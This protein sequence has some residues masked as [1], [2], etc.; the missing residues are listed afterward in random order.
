MM[1][2][3]QR[4]SPTRGNSDRSPR[5]LPEH[6]VCCRRVQ[7]RMRGEVPGRTGR[8][9]RAAARVGTPRS[10]AVECPDLHSARRLGGGHG[11]VNI[12][13]RFDRA[14]AALHIE[15]AISRFVRRGAECSEGDATRLCSSRSVGPVPATSTATPWLD[16]QTMA[17][18]TIVR[19]RG[20]SRFG[21]PGGI[22]TPDLLI[23]SQSL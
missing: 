2:K 6:A 7:A 4:L 1:A 3:P 15:D 13:T 17:P 20:C 9:T 8:R 22:R 10:A 14:R 16:R 5:L 12:D 18:E 23:R 21:P 11:R 19:G